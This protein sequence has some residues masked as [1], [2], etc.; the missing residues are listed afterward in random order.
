MITFLPQS[1][2]ATPACRAGGDLGNRKLTVCGSVATV[3]SL[4]LF[5]RV[6]IVRLCSRTRSESLFPSAIRP[7]PLLGRVADP[8]FKLL[9]HLD[10]D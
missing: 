1:C 9:L 2:D 8:G 6:M 5:P 4:Q 3:Q 7:H 10:H